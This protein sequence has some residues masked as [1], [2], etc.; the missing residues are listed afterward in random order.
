[1]HHINLYASYRKRTFAQ[2]FWNM[3]KAVF[4][5]MIAMSLL[6]YVFKI[7]DISRI[8]M[9]L[10]FLLNIGLLA[11]SKWITYETLTRY[12]KHPHHWIQ[13]K[14]QRRHQCSRRKRRLGI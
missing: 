10:F 2:I 13:R 8:M 12:S 9:G 7:T 5:G 11:F 1:M 3:V 6:I 14:S 4:T